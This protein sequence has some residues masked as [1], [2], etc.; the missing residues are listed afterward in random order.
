MF[1]SQPIRTAA[2]LGLLAAAWSPSA[3]AQD[4]YDFP[5]ARSFLDEHCRTCHSGASPAGGFRTDSLHGVASFATNADAWISLAARVSNHEMPPTG[6]PSPPLDDR[7]AFVAWVERTW[8]SQS[9]AA[10][11]P[12]TPSPIRRLNRD[13]YS[14][15]VRDLF[16][17]QI[18]VSEMFPVD[19]AGGEGFDNAAET[20]FLSPLLAEKYLAAAKF[21]LDVAAKEFK[22]RTKIFVAR[23]GPGMT[24][25]NASREILAKFLPIAFRQPVGSETVASY[26]RL[27]RRARRQGADFESSIF[28]ALRSALVS[29]AFLFH[30]RADAAAPRLAT[31]CIGF[32]AVLLPLGQPARRTPA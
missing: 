15:T 17:I 29:P 12:P 16:D 25:T 21:V 22:S 13:E 28:F 9:C 20:L 6:A 7:T 1:A 18:D 10:E 2:W 8:R 5:A 31:V 23:P 3:R 26:V 30:V 19:G 4:P 14:A 24:E 32:A 11:L 27:A